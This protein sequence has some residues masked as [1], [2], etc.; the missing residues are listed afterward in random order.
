M[1]WFLLKQ[2]YA[3][4]SLRL[5]C[6]I[7]LNPHER[8]EKQNVVFNIRFLMDD[9]GYRPPA[10]CVLSSSLEEKGSRE[11]SDLVLS[12]ACPRIRMMDPPSRPVLPQ[13]GQRNILITSALPYVN[14]VPHLGNIIGSVLSA[15][16]YARFSR[17]RARPTLFVCGTDEY[18]T[19]TEAK[20]LEDGVTPRELCDKYHALHAEIYEWFNI[21]FDYFGRT[22]TPEQTAI[23][24]DIFTKLRQNGNLEEQVTTQPYCESHASFLADRFIEGQC[25]NCGYM[26]ARGDQCEICSKLID[27]FELLNPRCKLDGAS[28]VP[29][30]TKHVY[31]SLEKLQPVVEEWTVRATKKG[32]WSHSGQVITESWLK[33]GLRSRSITRDLRW[34][35]PVPLPGYENKVL[36]VWFDACIGYISITANYT[37]EWQ[38]WWQ[39]PEQVSLYQFLGKDNVPFHTIVFPASQIGTGETWT[40]LHHLSATEYLNY[41]NGKFSKSR[42]VGVFGNNAKAT[43]VPA[44]V[45]RY[46]LLSSRPETQD[47]QFE[48][49][50]FM[51]KN[52][53]ELLGNLG[54][55]VNRLIKFTGVKF[56]QQVPDYRAALRQSAQ[57][58]DQDADTDCNVSVFETFIVEISALLNSYI[59]ELEAVHLRAGLEIAM[60]ISARGN[61]FLQ[62]N[63]LD[64]N[65]LTM[66]PSHAAGVVGLGLNL[67]Y[68]LASCIGPYMPATSHSMLQQL[69]S[70][71][72]LLLD[73]DSTSKGWSVAHHFLPVGHSIGAASYLF[74]KIDSE[75]EQE[76]REAFGGS[77]AR[78]LKEQE[79]AKKAAKKKAKKTRDREKNSQQEVGKHDPEMSTLEADLHVLQ[80]PSHPII[81][82]TNHE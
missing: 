75:K 7:G 1:P 41:E 46:Y 5:A 26:D 8:L 56:N 15:D 69:G 53:T 74:A 66:H 19:A 30:Q 27:P 70:P 4:T 57:D 64:N 31:L 52:N 63:R 47:S 12:T 45:W 35:T 23:A 42:N 34:G 40:Q 73:S 22:T 29:R 58:G 71:P 38:R 48:W 6:I 18:G 37:S 3:L 80:I 82:Q 44:D 16:V 79:A 10:G 13:E 43:G 28:P 39:N 67:I 51:R 21:G 24:Q 2:E 17:L 61:L 32:I 50:T 55:F 76:W 65:L 9:A 77:R 68:L 78:E 59:T 11:E 20:A 33:E 60:S 62:Q 72:Q 49:S 25:P 36:Y 54:N 81:K 14:N